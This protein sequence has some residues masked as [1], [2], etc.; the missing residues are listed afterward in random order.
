MFATN[1]NKYS[2]TNLE[3]NG[4]SALYYVVRKHSVLLMLFYVVSYSN[5]NQLRRFDS[6]LLFFWY[7][8]KSN[9]LYYSLNCH[10]S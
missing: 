9:T 6:R 10:I 8:K 4:L 1:K 5:M 2:P 7:V 3:L